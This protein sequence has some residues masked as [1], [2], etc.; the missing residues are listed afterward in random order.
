MNIESGFTG[1]TGPRTKVGGI[2]VAVTTE[3]IKISNDPN[4]KVKESRNA[5]PLGPVCQR[6][7]DSLVSEAKEATGSA[8]FQKRAR[9]RFQARPGRWGAVSITRERNSA[10]RNRNAM[11]SNVAAAAVRKDWYEAGTANAS[12]SPCLPGK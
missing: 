1:A 9:L 11:S 5:A 4:A 12:V 3:A 8:E 2:R 10:Q 6:D 7:H